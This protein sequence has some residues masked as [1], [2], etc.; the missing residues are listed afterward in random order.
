MK[1]YL[2]VLSLFGLACPIRAQ[3]GQQAPD[4]CPPG[5]TFYAGKCQPV[6]D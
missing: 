1:V 2:L 6:R 4:P 5:E 3:R